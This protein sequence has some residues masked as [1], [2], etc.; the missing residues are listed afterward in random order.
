MNSNDQYH[1]FFSI[2]PCPNKCN[3]LQYKSIIAQ[4]GSTPQL[5]TVYS[6]YLIIICNFTVNVF[7]R[8]RKY[9]KLLYCGIYTKL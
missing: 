9:W 7:Y 6:I 5:P 3:D 4:A 2:L 8:V 1:F